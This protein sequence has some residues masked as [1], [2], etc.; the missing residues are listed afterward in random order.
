MSGVESTQQRTGRRLVNV[1]AVLGLLYL[2][3][4]IIVIVAFSFNEPVGKYNI[5]WQG[6]TLDNWASPFSDEALTDALFVSLRVA[7]ISSVIA[8]VL[9]TMIALS[10]SRFRFKGS[11]AVNLFLVLPLTS[12]EVVLGSSLA[13]LFLS[14]GVDFGYTTVIIAHVMFQISFVAVTVRARI[15]GFDWTL[16]QAAMDLGASPLRAFWRIT[17]PLILPG[18]LAAWLLS[19]ALSIDDFIITFFNAGS[20]VTFPLQIFGA[21]RVAI[22]PQI[23]VLASMLLLLSIALMVGALLIESRRQRMIAS[24]ALKRKK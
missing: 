7:L 18:I 10:L 5:V 1:A 9:G 21:S 15:R 22:P 3:A 2:F 12:P 13:T 11:G 6:F 16:E 20:L 8:A 17:F 14:R 23:N 24:G 4:P 19:F